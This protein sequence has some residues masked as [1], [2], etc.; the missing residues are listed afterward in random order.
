MK[1]IL[2]I[3]F[4]AKGV[5]DERSILTTELARQRGPSPPA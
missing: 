4:K 3:L 5:L 2:Q 1:Y